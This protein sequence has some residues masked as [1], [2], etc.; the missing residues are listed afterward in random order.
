VTY[1][2]SG[3][4]SLS[5]VAAEEF[6]HR[7]ITQREI[8]GSVAW[9]DYRGPPGTIRTVS[10]SRA[11]KGEVD[12]AFFRGKV[13]VVGATASTLQDIHATSDS[14]DMSGAEIHANAIDT[15]LRGAPL[16][17]SGK[18]IDVLLV[19][20]LAFFAPLISL[21][22]KPLPALLASAGLG[23]LFAVGVQLAFN[24]ATIVPFVYPLLALVLSVLGS[25]VVHYRTVESELRSLSEAIE[26][27]VEKVGP[28]DTLGDYRVEE[29]L[30]RGGM[31]VVY[32]ATQLSLD[33]EVAL[34]V[35][36]PELAEDPEY[37]SRFQ[38]EAMLA[39]SI[40]HPNVVPVYEAGEEGGLLFLAMRLIVGI[41]LRHLLQQEGP[42]PPARAAHMISQVAAAL[43]A[44]HARG[45][46][47]RDVK[48]ANVLDEPAAGDHVYLTDFGLTR[49]IDS[50]SQV[51]QEGTMMGTLDY[52]PPEQINGQVVDAR[53]DVY[54]LG[55]VLYE[56]LTGRVPFERDSEVAKLFA[57]VSSDVPSAREARPELTERIDE[58]IRRAMAKQ[59]EERYAS[60]EEFARDAVAALAEVSANADRAGT[61]APHPPSRSA[62]TTTVI[63]PGESED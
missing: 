52:I 11:L 59:P 39:A 25:L 24:G 22:L 20:L 58:V 13:V 9:I 45:L 30:A 36:V 42:L 63:T 62:S 38:R 6:E 46:V 1:E 49:R 10:F 23:A 26:R 61:E 57:H 4:K 32:R 48:P 51:T 44:A 60:V 33:R 56:M 29:L 12:P 18:A 19:L 35:I 16:R 14:P 34:K 17:Q 28:G 37:R 15:V 54:A 21:R 43:G 3:L 5:V 47:H 53:A 31:G 27:L 7:T 50:A 41:D 2:T 55:C 8:G 40:N